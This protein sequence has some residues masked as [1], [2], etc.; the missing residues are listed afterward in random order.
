MY[1]LIHN[2]K[3]ILGPMGWNRA[4]FE[5]TL[6]RLNKTF[7]LPRLDP[8]ELPIVI[9][10]DTKI[11]QASIIEPSYIQ[12]IQYLHGPFWD[13]TQ[14]TVVGT[15]QVKETPLELVKI[16]V[17]AD[18]AAKR[19]SKENEGIKIII[20]DMEVTLDTS[21]EIRNVYFQKL[22]LLNDG[23]TLNW[24]FPEGWVEINKQELTSMARAVMDYVQSVFDWELAA[25][26]EVDAAEYARDL[27]KFVLDDGNPPP[28][29]I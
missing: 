20:Q 26:E 17:K 2:Y 7:N 21:R 23:E 12:K 5:G 3:V 19:Y 11:C 16:T 29:M 14:P 28:A 24:K 15:Y 1:V 10:D 8:V 4:M 18:I 27:T 9:D 6:E 13:L 22:A 25:I